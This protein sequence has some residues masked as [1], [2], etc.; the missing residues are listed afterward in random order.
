M[1]TADRKMKR[2]YTAAAQLLIMLCGMGFLLQTDAYYTPYRLVAAAAL[3]CMWKS[4]AAAG[5]ACIRTKKH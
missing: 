1:K 2:T 4:G 5:T 3:F